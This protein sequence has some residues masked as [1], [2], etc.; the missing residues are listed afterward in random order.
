[1][2]IIQ[3]WN[4]NIT[5]DVKNN[6]F[7]IQNLWSAN[8][9]KNVLKTLFTKNRKI[10][11]YFYSIQIPCF[12]MP[13]DLF[14]MVFDYVFL[15][16]SSIKKLVKNILTWLKIPLWHYAQHWLPGCMSVLVLKTSQLTFWNWETFCKIWA[17]AKL[18]RILLFW[19]TQLSLQR[20]ISSNSGWSP[21]TRFKM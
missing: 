8:L 19:W 1:M 4:T 15:A 21:K 13:F 5:S 20:I 9:T 10:L 6:I 14:C 16:K 12:E 17:M 2:C 18:I 3:P 7:F 11:Y